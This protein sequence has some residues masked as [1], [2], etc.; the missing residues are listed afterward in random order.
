MTLVLSTT[1]A[2]G[3]TGVSSHCFMDMLSLTKSLP[4]PASSLVIL[5]EEAHGEDEHNILM[6]NC[7]DE[8]KCDFSMS[9]PHSFTTS[10][11]DSINSTKSRAVVF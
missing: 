4:A 5:T 11:F 7:C 8:N 2:C 9:N 1:Q 10:C 3:L 6:V